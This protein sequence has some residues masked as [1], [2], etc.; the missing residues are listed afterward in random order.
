MIRLVHFV[1]PVSWI[2][3]GLM[4]RSGVRFSGTGAVH[5][6]ATMGDPPI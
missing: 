6:E 2:P 4:T 3:I 5:E 1:V